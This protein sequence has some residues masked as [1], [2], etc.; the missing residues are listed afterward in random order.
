MAKEAN[1]KGKKQKSTISFK[2]SIKTKLI[3]VMI[4]ITAIPLIVS[5]IVSYRSSTNKALD[6]AVANLNWQAKYIAS[7]FEDTIDKNYVAMQTIAAAPST[8]DFMLHPDDPVAMTKTLEFL[9]AVDKNLNDGNITVLT[10][11]DGMQ[12]LRA[13]G[14][15]VD[16][17][18]REYFQKAMEGNLWCS[19]VIVSA[20][21]GARQCTFSA[22]VYGDGGAVIGI[23]QRN[24]DMNVLHEFLA[25]ESDDAFIT[26][27]AGLVA[28]HSQ[29]EITAENEDDRSQST[30]MTSG[31]DSGTYEA[32]TGKG[33]R[34]IVCYTKSPTIGWT[35]C[36]ASDTKTV[37]AS[38]RSAAT[39]VVIIGIVMLIIAILISFMMARNFTDPIKVVNDAITQLADGRFSKVSKHQNRKDELGQMIGNTNL[40]IDK[41]KEIVTNIKESANNVGINSEELSDMA[42]QISQTAEDVSNAV[43]EIASGATQQADEIQH[44]SENVGRI[45]DA[46]GDVQN[47]TG[48]LSNLAEKMKE[49]SEVSSTSLASLQDSSNEMT[50]KIDEISKTISATQDAVTNINGKVEGIASIA[51]QTNLLSLNASIEAARAGEAGK[52]FAVVAE[53]IGKLADDSKQMA[54]DIRKEMDILLEQ[55]KAAVAAADDVRQGNQDQQLALGETLEA[56]NGMLADIGST[57]GGVQLISQGA[58]TCETSK[59]AVVDT[60]SALSAISEENAA[61]SEETGAS[62]QELSAT[63]TT[64]AGSANN[65]KDI[66]D[67]L[68]EDIAF[69]KD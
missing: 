48:D 38:A 13:S 27:R 34:A 21:T 65:L 20:S 11:P 14:K 33:Y 52:G 57:V 30:F 28:A 42:N 36:T 23:V 45:G 19:D 10:G 61:S 32:D 66:S 41:L 56:V 25:S 54:D 8:R 50:A 24:F 69:F 31:L 3:A 53:E 62:M 12:V 2:D 55:S 17:S 59:N 18:K 6:D 35:I 9:S 26:D 15:L 44:A 37:T 51:T 40:V 16:V 46:V 1:E 64:L 7:E 68:N 58:D 29:Y 5:L 22:P 43:Q 60:M 4:L 47:S 39:V 67:K 63:V 49:A